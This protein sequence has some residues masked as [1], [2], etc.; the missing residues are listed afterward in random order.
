MLGI[1]F[2]AAILGIIIAVMEQ[3]R[4]PGWGNMVGCVLVPSITA[5]F[6]NLFLPPFLFFI[7]SAVGALCAIVAISYLCQMSV[8]RASIAAGIYWAIQTAISFALYLM[9]NV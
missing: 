5:F 2:G 1:L 9:F 6:I 4:F 7:G 3:E 8:I